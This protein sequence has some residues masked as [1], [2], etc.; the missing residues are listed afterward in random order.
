MAAMRK[1]YR[2]TDTNLQKNKVIK[3]A[4]YL[5]TND[6][7][8]KWIVAD[9]VFVARVAVGCWLLLVVYPWSR[10]LNIDHNK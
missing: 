5:K 3:D 7:Y 2:T 6:Q 8:L 4:L 10:T 1:F 9:V